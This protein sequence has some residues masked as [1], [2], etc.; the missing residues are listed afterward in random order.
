MTANLGRFFPWLL[1]VHWLLMVGGVVS[2]M[3]LILP[4]CLWNKSGILQLPGG[5]IWLVLTL[6]PLLGLAAIKWTN[7]RP[8]YLAFVIATPLFAALV[9]SLNAS[10]VAMCDVP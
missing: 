4:F 6:S 10:G 7:L 2:Q 5:L 8:T 9:L 3:W 1:A